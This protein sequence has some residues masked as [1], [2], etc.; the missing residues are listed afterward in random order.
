MPLA[1]GLWGA[2]SARRPRGCARSHA[3]LAARHVCRVRVS[4]P[5]PRLREAGQQERQASH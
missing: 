3:R 2:A 1:L 5:G 4:P